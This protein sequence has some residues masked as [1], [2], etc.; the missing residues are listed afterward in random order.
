MQNTC[1][2]NSYSSPLLKVLGTIVN[3]YGYDDSSKGSTHVK[4]DGWSK[5]PGTCLPLV[6]GLWLTN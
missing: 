1:N 5:T 6:N 3:V 4:C 2:V